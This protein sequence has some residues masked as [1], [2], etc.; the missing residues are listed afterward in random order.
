[1]AFF[2][3]RYPVTVIAVKV[4]RKHLLIT[5]QEDSATRTDSNGMSECQTY[6]YERDSNGE[7]YEFVQRKNRT[8]KGRN[9]YYSLSLG[10]REKYHDYSF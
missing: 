2:T 3:D 10:F 6:D 9:H 7:M 1:M 8:L 4:V 5:V